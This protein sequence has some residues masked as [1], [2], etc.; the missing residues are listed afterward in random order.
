MVGE[1]GVINKPFL[2]F[3]LLSIIHSSE[4]KQESKMKKA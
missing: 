1:R 2:R 4:L 3:Y